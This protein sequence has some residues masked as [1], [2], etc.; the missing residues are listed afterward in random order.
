MDRS[1][2]LSAVENLLL[3][4]LVCIAG[5]IRSVLPPGSFDR[6]IEVDVADGDAG[7]AIGRA[8]LAD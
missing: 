5:T 4:L 7:V 3:F 2:L 8:N 6:A 1:K